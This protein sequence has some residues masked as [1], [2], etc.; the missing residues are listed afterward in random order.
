MLIPT[1]V[2]P[3]LWVKGVILVTMRPVE[4]S[5]RPINQSAILLWVPPIVV[6]ATVRD[7][8]AWEGYSTTVSLIPRMCRVQP[9][10]M[11]IIVLARAGKRRHLLILIPP[12]NAEYAMASVAVV[13]R[14]PSMTIPA[15][16]IIAAPRAATILR[17]SR[18][19]T[20]REILTFLQMVT[21]AK[22]ATPQEPLRQ[23]S[24]IIAG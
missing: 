9:A 5:G 1:T 11:P 18:V 6:L 24:M 19:L 13:L 21:I 17:Q 14:M 10:T 20:P 2:A 4:D 15:S 12:P 16:R 7:S 8:L 3:M 23:G 22:I